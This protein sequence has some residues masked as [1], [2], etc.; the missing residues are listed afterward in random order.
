MNKEN[1]KLKG[2]SLIELVLYVG[3]LAFLLTSLGVLA[4]TSFKTRSRQQVVIEVEQQGMA[5]T[6]IIS[7]TIRNSSSITL[8]AAG[9]SATSVTLTV[10]DAAKTPTVFSLSGT[11]FQMIEN[12]TATLLTNTQVQ[13]SDLSF[14]N[15]SAV[16]T[17]GTVKFQFTLSYA[18]SGG[19]PQFNY[20][21]VFYG[22]AS[23]R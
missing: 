22:S 13:V 10:P 2:F 15:L 6:Q 1:Q 4:N 5:I 17:P 18:N 12:S 20:S 19:T 3:L 7:Q 16:A 9:S 23:L 14:K 11:T 21:K 8:P